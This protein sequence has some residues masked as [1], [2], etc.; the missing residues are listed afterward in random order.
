MKL[1]EIIKN[2][3]IGIEAIEKH[4]DVFDEQEKEDY[5][6]MVGNIEVLIKMAEKEGK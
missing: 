2:I 1:D 5:F 3:N 6:W 4:L